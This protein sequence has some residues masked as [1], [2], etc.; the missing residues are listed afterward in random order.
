MQ[1]PAQCAGVCLCVGIANL[2]R[3][4]QNLP[5]ARIGTRP[6]LLFFMSYPLSPQDATAWLRLSYAGLPTHRARA[7]LQHFGSPH[8]IF[9]AAHNEGKQ[10][11]DEFKLTERALEKLRGCTTKDVERQLDSM[12]A[13]NIGV[14][15]EAEFPSLLRQ[16]GDDVPAFLFVRGSFS[17]RDERTIGIVGTRNMTEY[18]R[19]LAHTFGV[20][21]ARA[22]W[23]VASGLARGIDTAGHMGALDGGGRTIAATGCGLDIVYPSENRELMTRIEAAGAVLSEWAPTTP[24]EPW[25]FPARN[26]IIVGLSRAVIVVEAQQ[27][28]GALITATLAATHDR[29]VFA[30]PGNIHK[31]QSRGPH[32]LIKE[33]AELMES[34]DD[35]LEF[36]GAEVR[37]IEDDEDEPETRTERPIEI[38]SEMASVKSQSLELPLGA[39]DAPVGEQNGVRKTP[40]RPL[41]SKRVREEEPVAPPTNLAP[42]ELRLYLLLEADPRHMDDL[43]EAASLEPGPTN[44]ALVMLELKGFARRLPGNLFVKPAKTT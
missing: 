22:G 9:D 21:L 4:G 30:V 37:F 34:V 23:T 17:P 39:S 3:R 29:T 43:A 7:L 19:G 16:I 26:R 6:T 10:L 12:V 13:H 24:P 14:A 2:G 44:A 31:P 35:V 15:T 11:R 5:D 25:H 36:L 18:G 41:A 33:G 8:T 1:T 38:R 27:K 20:E 32:Q 40:P 42:N 28:S